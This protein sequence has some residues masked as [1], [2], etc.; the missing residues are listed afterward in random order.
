MQSKIKEEKTSQHEVRLYVLSVS[1][2]SQY[3]SMI[4]RSGP[5]A[6]G[7]LGVPV[8]EDTVVL[9]AGVLQP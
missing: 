4:W 6:A 5:S 2:W 1:M 3:D 7:L 9:S 8:T